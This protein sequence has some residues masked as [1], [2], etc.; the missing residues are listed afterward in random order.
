MNADQLDSTIRDVL[1]HWTPDNPAAPAGLADR[2]VRRRRRRNRARVSGAALALAGITVGAVLVTG[3]GDHSGQPRPA[4]QVSKESKLWWHTKLPTSSLDACTLGPGAV[5]CRG[6]AYDAVSLDV[7]TGKVAWQRK[8]AHP[9][10]GSTPSGSVPGARDGV[11][12]TFADHAPNTPRAGTDL[13]ALDMDSRRVLWRHELADDSRGPISAIMFDGG[14]LAN[15]PTFKKVAALDDKT[16]RTLWT[17]AWKQA[18][19]DRAVIRGVPYLTCSPDSAKA[20]QQSSVVRLDPATGE[21]R[22]VATVKGATALLGT[23]G[24]TVLLAGP[25]G[26]RKTF[27]RPGPVILTRVDTG[28]GKVTQH[29]ADRLPWGTVADGVIVGADGKG[30]AVAY[31]AADGTRLWAR[32]L[33]LK[34]REDHRFDDRELPSAAAVD[35][36]TRVAY[37]M[38]PSGNLVGVDLDNGAV[39]WRGRA[40]VA[41]GPANGGVAPELMVHDHGLVGQT[42]GE[43]FRIE[44]KLK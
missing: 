3:G 23:D 18:D 6:T 14:V 11:L 19:C 7:R 10:D 28:S 30:R 22:T 8:A 16:G 38:D 1:T 29:R 27:S 39:R 26:G 24:D 44:P 9:N 41:K 35:L 32:D 36:G 43:L 13:V 33:G 20:P 15:T 25:A 37:F 5:Y 40:P 4:G 12:Y 17:H 2:I 21:A 42:G 31:S 34:L